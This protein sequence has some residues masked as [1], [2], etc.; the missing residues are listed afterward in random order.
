MGRIRKNL[1][2]SLALERFDYLWLQHLVPENAS[3]IH[4]AVDRIV[5]F[6][7]ILVSCPIY[8]VPNLVRHYRKTTSHFGH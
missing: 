8:R 1:T 4:N 6:H 3:G 7:W 2:V 5:Q